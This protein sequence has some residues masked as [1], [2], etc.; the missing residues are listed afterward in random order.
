MR[1]AKVVFNAAG[2][3]GIIVLTPL[4]FLVDLTGRRYAPPRNLPQFLYGFYRWQ[5]RCRSPFS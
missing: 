4:D 1:F 3:C 5:W 2:V